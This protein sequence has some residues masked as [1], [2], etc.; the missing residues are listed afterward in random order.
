[1][2]E[3][4]PFP[5]DQA[6][7]G[8]SVRFL[9]II[10]CD[11]MHDEDSCEGNEQENCLWCD[12]ECLSA[13]RV[14][15]EGS[16]LLALMLIAL[17]VVLAILVLFCLARQAVLHPASCP[18]QVWVRLRVRSYQFF[19]GGNLSEDSESVLKRSD[20]VATTQTNQY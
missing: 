13:D 17:A 14:C 12:D 18:G 4:V 16:S 20:S 3:T 6:V 19:G 9:H 5:I 10:D 8:V 11:K 7:P 1:M 2:D 15:N